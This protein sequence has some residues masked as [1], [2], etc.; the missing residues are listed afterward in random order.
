MI[1]DKKKLEKRYNE[2]RYHDINRVVMTDTKELCET[3][4]KLIKAISNSIY[5]TQIIYEE[6]NLNIQPKSWKSNI[7]FSPDRTFQAAKKYIWK[8]TAVLDFANSHSPWGAPFSSSA[9]EESLCRTSTLFPCISTDETREKYYNYHIEK[10]DRGELDVY[11]ND[12]MIYI[13]DVVVFKSDTAIPD[14]IPES[15]RFNVDVILACAPE[16]FKIISYDEKSYKQ[17]MR[18]RIKRILDIAYMNNIE[19][20]ILWAFWCWAFRNPPEIIAQL[21][22]EELANYDFENI[23]FAIYTNHFW[24]KDNYS[25]FK[26]IFTGEGRKDIYNLERFKEA[27]SKSYKTALEEIR[28]WRKETHWMWYMFPQIEGLGQSTLSKKYAIT[29]LEE[30]KAYLEDDELRDHLIEMSL[31]LLDLKEDISEDIFWIIDAM[32]LQSCMTLFA[33]AEP[34]NDIFTSVLNKFYNWEFDLK[35]LSIL[36]VLGEELHAKIEK[37]KYSWKEIWKDSEE[38]K[39]L[40]E[41]RDNFIKKIKM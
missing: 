18:Q 21:F 1:L 19:C 20:L 25:I 29:S 31:A 10:Y 24:P 6:N 13:P 7:I 16:L 26:E 9:Q 38:Y 32:K 37:R 15:E 5:H 39:Q 23:E 41:K 2:W 17:I 4:P 8:K 35:T 11:W 28:N 34:D 22:K 33:Q 27:Q 36:G 12:D 14:L 40:K 3:D 30:A